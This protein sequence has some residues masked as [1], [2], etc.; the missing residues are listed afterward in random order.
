MAWGTFRNI[1][2]FYEEIFLKIHFSGWFSEPI[3]MPKPDFSKK[4]KIQNLSLIPQSDSCPK[5]ADWAIL[6]DSENQ[7]EKWIFK[8]IAS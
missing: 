2:P 5:K 4:K 7:L 6:I 8:N 3:K 1:L